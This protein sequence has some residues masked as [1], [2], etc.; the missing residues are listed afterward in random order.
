[1]SDLCSLGVVGVKVLDFSSKCRVIFLAQGPVNKVSVLR[2][3][4]E[5]EFVF[6][7]NGGVVLSN[8]TSMEGMGVDC[9]AMTVSGEEFRKGGVEVIRDERGDYVFFAIWDDKK[10]VGVLLKLSCHPGPGWTPG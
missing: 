3:L 10:V 2:T 6:G 5:Q 9:A 7:G 1:M 8:W 4:N